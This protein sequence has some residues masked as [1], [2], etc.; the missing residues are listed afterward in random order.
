MH[1]IRYNFKVRIY[2]RFYD[3]FVIKTQI[4]QE[5]TLKRLAIN[6]NQDKNEIKMEKVRFEMAAFVLCI[7]FVLWVVMSGCSNQEQKELSGK[8]DN[9][10]ETGVEELIIESPSFENSS[11]IPVRFSCKGADVNPE[12]N[13]RNI[14]LNTKSLV[15]IMDD[16]DAPSGTWTHWILYDILPLFR[17]SSVNDAS[18]NNRSALSEFKIK[19]A[20]TPVGAKQGKNSW[21][22]LSYRGPCPPSGTHRY[23]FSIY[24]LDT[25]LNLSEGAERKEIEK[26]MKS[27]II[28]KGVLMGFF[29]K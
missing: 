13:V 26:G 17:K 29:S 25:L 9:I 20:Q 11:P 2:D 27:H 4:T 8:Q 15:I 24:A 28:G 23:F 3:R 21:G 16:P 1:I 5:G 19:E 18:S 7:V 22:I 12:L 14:P 6:Q 10:K